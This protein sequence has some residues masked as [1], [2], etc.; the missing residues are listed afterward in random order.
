M[1]GAEG[2]GCFLMEC[3]CGVGSDSAVVGWAVMECRCGV[4]SDGV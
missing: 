2:G 1:G 3:R 4:G